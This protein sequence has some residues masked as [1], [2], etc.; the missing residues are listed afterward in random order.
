MQSLSA[1]D[2]KIS[3]DPNIRPEL[4][5][6]SESMTLV[7]EV[8]RNCS[9]L[10]PGVAELLSLSGESSVEK[11]VESCFNNKRLE[12]IAIKDG[13]RGCVIHTR[14][15]SFKMGVY[16]VESKDPTG[17]GDCFDGAFI[18]GIIEGLPLRDCAKMASAAAALN[19]AAFGPMEGDINKDT[20]YRMISSSPV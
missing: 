8:F 12:C 5:R 2:V 20:I 7:N 16:P 1:K 3:F 14:K 13:S 6:N 9:I 4:L 17:A 15:E 10:M 18:S 11:A 19:T